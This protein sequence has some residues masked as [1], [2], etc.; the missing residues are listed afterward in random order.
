MDRK[1]KRIKLLVELV[2]RYGK[3][4]RNQIKNSRIAPKKSMKGPRDHKN[5]NG[6]GSRTWNIQSIS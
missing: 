1:N 3:K 6:G 4:E 5:S 2:T